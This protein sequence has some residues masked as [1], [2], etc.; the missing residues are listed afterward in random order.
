MHRQAPPSER[1][2]RQPVSTPAGVGAQ[3][4]R[5]TSLL[6]AGALLGTLA[7]GTLS[8]AG[9][10]EVVTFIVSG[11]TLALLAGLVSD[12][13]DQLVRR[14]GPTTTGVVQAALGN[15]PELFISI[16]ALRAGLVVVVQASL[17]GSILGN[18]LLILGIAFL[19]G[20]LR[21]GTQRFNTDTPRLIATVMFV[22]VAALVVPTMATRLGGPAAAH[23]EELSVFVAIALLVVFVGSLVAS[24]RGALPVVEREP[25]GR[26]AWSLSLTLAVL[27][28]TA[29]GAAFVAHWFVGA[30]QPAAQTLGLSQAF[31]GLVIVALAG[32]AVEHVV[33]VQLAVRNDMDTALSIILNSSMQI[34][35]GLFPLLVVLSL[36]IGGAHLTLVLA[37]LLV[38][39][40]ALTALLSAVVV[41]DG[42]SNWVEG[43]ALVG[44]YVI[45]AAA[46]WWG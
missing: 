46:F 21:H 10:P 6:L 31:V 24:L 9:A 33:G 13:T 38:A 14:L 4:G 5:G 40:L 17:V 37:P 11:A 28:A 25:G 41:F 1:L 2:A 42:E 18:S 7:S 32:N 23:Q 22:S 3:L 43:M 26:P 20:G 16:F 44:L 36:V 8:G 45:I 19:A 35:L 12:A 34:A 29:L 39:A 27:G 15:L 30:L